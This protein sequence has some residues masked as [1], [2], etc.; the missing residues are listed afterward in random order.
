[1]LHGRS[2]KRWI[3]TRARRGETILSFTGLSVTAFHTVCVATRARKQEATVPR[4]TGCRR[5]PGYSRRRQKRR[6]QLQ[7]IKPRRGRAPPPAHMAARASI[8]L[9]AVPYYRD[10]NKQAICLSS[11][12]FFLSR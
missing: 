9:G 8:Q 12:F 1:M 6:L 3:T 10:L 2:V 11:P 4:L 7:L 5:F